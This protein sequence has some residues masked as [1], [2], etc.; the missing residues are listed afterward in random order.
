VV[1]KY[2]LEREFANI[3]VPQNKIDYPTL[4]NKTIKHFNITRYV[5]EKHL[6]DTRYK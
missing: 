3:I 6:L 2:K 1:K 5:A 4:S